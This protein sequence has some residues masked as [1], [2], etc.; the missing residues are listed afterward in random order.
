MIFAVALGSCSKNEPNVGD[1]SDAAS[2]GSMV[3]IN[4]YAGTTKATD[5]TTETLETAAW[6]ELHIDDSADISETFKFV[7]DGS[8]WSQESDDPILWSDI[9]FPANFYSMHDGAP[10]EDLTYNDDS[11]T[12]S[13]YTVTGTSEEHKDLVFHASTLTTAPSSRVVSAAH[14]HALSKINLYAAT[15]TTNVYIAKVQMVSIDGEGDVTI[16]PL[17]ADALSTDTG[18]TWVNSGT[19]F[20]DYQ[21]YFIDDSSPV[22]LNSTLYGSNPIINSDEVAPLMIIPQETTAATI[23]ED[24][25][26]G[27]D[28]IVSNSYIEVIYY[29]TDAN[30]SPVVGYSSVSELSNA[31]DYIDADQTTTLYVKAG[32]PLGYEF[33]VNKEYDITLGLG[34]TGSTGGVLLAD[35]YVDKNGDAVKLTKVDDDGDGEDEDEEVVEVPEIDEGDDILAGDDEVDIVVSAGTWDDGGSVT[36]EM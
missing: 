35:Y 23:T 17:A 36:V 4:V 6:V 7:Y 24:P 21:Y 33:M 16:T 1:N 13:G 9:T 19:E 10:F 25:D 31:S 30:G 18:A 12:Y 32:F 29:M 3:A 8:D 34:V 5:T 2:D 20:E 15:G 11:A 22:A 28:A 26:G 14:T 27:L